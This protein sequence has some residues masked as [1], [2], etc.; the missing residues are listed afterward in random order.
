MLERD[1][2]N[3]FVSVLAMDFKWKHPFT[4]KLQKISNLLSFYLILLLFIALVSGPT[5]SGKSTFVSKFLK[6]L[7]QMVDTHIHEIVYCAPENSYPDLTQCITP[8][9]YLDGLPDQT[10]F[11]DKLPRLVVIDDLQRQSDASVVDLFT[12]NSHHLSVSVMFICQNIFYKGKG[13]RDI[14]L[15]AHYIVSYKNPR[16]RVQFSTLARQVCPQNSAYMKEIFEDATSVPYGYLVMDLTQTTPD[17]LRYRTKIFP[18][19]EPSN[20][21]YVQKGYIV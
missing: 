4:C 13:Q 12:T 21:I 9:R 6:Y 18:E 5:G 7:D 2:E 19:D 16:D 15:N 1:E 17:H 3:I 14:S 11:S 20:V 10:L 8:I